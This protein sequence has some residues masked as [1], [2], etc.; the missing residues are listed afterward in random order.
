[1]DQAFWV[2]ATKRHYL[3]ADRAMWRERAAKLAKSGPPRLRELAALMAVTGERVE[4]EALEVT[5][6][7]VPTLADRLHEIHKLHVPSG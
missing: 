5:D 1:M 4:Q 6:R 7:V 3:P 2:T